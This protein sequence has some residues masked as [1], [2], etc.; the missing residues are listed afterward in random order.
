MNLDSTHGVTVGVPA[1]GLFTRV[2]VNC[3]F[4]WTAFCEADL[5]F[6]TR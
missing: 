3:F 2:V 1:L 5:V 4:L 6:G